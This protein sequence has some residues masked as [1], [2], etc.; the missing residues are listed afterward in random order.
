MPY[1]S[2]MIK[3]FVV[4]LD[5][6]KKDV[7]YP[8]STPVMQTL[9]LKLKCKSIITAILDMIHLVLILEI[10]MQITYQMMLN[11]TT[12]KLDRIHQVKISQL[13]INKLIWITQF[14]SEQTFLG[15]MAHN[16]LHSL[17]AVTIHVNSF[18][19]RQAMLLCLGVH[20]WKKV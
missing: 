15:M 18:Q 1:T 19:A 2:M 20:L 5:L 10:Q 12:V 4:T 3:C 6:V 13:I 8:M 16:G 17:K 11:L 9:F 7:W 14:L